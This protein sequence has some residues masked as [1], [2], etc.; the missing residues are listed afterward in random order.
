MILI[1]VHRINKGTYDQFTCNQIYQQQQLLVGSNTMFGAGVYAYYHNAV[2]SE[3]RDDPHVV[4]QP[5]PNRAELHISHIILPGTNYSPDSRFFVL[6]A[7]CNSYVKI[8]VL[9]FVNCPSP[10]LPKYPGQLIFI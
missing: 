7:P 6:P 9:G 4:F 3:W 8:A 2:P 5:L 1:G 10:A